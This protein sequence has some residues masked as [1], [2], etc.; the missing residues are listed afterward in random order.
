MAETYLR[1]IAEGNTKNFA[2][3]RLVRN[4]FERCIDRQATRIVQDENLT[5]EDLIT[6][7]REDMIEGNVVNALGKEEAEKGA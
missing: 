3:A 1:G 5:E 6:F 7:V 2:N 4:Y